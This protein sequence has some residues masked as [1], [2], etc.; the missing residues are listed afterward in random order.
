MPRASVP[1]ANP[2]QDAMS[3]AQSPSRLSRCI[4]LTVQRPGPIHLPVLHI[5]S[6]H[7]ERSRDIS[8]YL[9]H[10]KGRDSSTTL[11]TTGWLSNTEF[12]HSSV[13]LRHFGAL[14]PFHFP[15]LQQFVWNFF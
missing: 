5:E 7:V 10:K 12:R 15:V 13:E 2:E 11:G 14:A 4:V 8:D 1:P 3:S 9:K 6:C